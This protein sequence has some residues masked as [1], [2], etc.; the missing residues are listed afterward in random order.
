MLS[1]YALMKALSPRRLNNGV[2][3]FSNDEYTHVILK[4]EKI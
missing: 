4:K 2:I 3:R 1:G